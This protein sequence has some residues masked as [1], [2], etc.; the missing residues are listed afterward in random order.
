LREV[1]LERGADVHLTVVLSGLTFK[2]TKKHEKMI[3]LLMEHCKKDG[4]HRAAGRRNVDEYGSGCLGRLRADR[5]AAMPR[6]SGA[7][8]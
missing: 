6:I 4:S 8:R 7:T 5:P 3:G 2:T 1:L